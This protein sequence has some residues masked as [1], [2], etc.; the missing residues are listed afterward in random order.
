MRS[1]W[2]VWKPVQTE[3]IF[4]HVHVKTTQHCQNLHLLMFKFWHFAFSMFLQWLLT[5]YTLYQWWR[6]KLYTQWKW[7]N[8][9]IYFKI[10]SKYVASIIVF[11][12]LFKRISYE[13]VCRHNQYWVCSNKQILRLVTVLWLE[14][15]SPQTNYLSISKVGWP[16]MSRTEYFCIILFF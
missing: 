15:K 5:E 3:N 12:S 6:Y 16:A 8:S 13:A 1:W 4:I 7:C 11:Y 2:H 14:V 9:D 10:H